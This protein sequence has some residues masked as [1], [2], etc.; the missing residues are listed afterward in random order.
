MQ[1]KTGDALRPVWSRTTGPRVRIVLVEPR[2]E[3]NIGA[4]ARA[5]RVC[6]L[7]ELAIVGLQHP[8]DRGTAYAMA[9]GSVDILQSALIVDSL[10]DALQGCQLAIA[11]T[12]RPRHSSHVP[13][14]PRDL[15]KEVMKFDQ[16]AT[17]ALVFGREDSGLSND[18]MERCEIWA[19]IP[20]AVVYPSY[21]LAQSVQ[22]FC[23]EL[24][25]AFHEAPE[26]T[27][28]L[29]SEPEQVDWLYRRMRER[30]ELNGFHPRDG[31]DNFINHARGVLG[32][33]VAD[34]HAAGFIHKLLD[35]LL[36]IRTK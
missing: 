18:E 27:S 36:G 35:G 26:Q 25:R 7:N 30:L 13:M 5:L 22:I 14:D 1:M 6:G 9:W 15:A 29:A 28:R 19:S 34:K 3:G 20:A 17:I 8:L 21:N 23:Y 10:E 2:N 4:T 33:V 11:T 31:M 24:F 16:S 12:A 32:P